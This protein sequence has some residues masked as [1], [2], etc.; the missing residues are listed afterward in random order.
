MYVYIYIYTHMYICMCVYIYIYIY[1]FL[2]IY[3]CMFPP[4]VTLV[5][6]AFRGIPR[7]RP[8]SLGGGIGLD[9]YSNRK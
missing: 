3:L 9:K 5:V 4:L 8:A 1:I 6:E 7:P 2:F